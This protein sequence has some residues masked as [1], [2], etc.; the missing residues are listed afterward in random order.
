MVELC[1]IFNYLPSSICVIVMSWVLNCPLNCS[2]STP[3]PS[4]LLSGLSLKWKCGGCFGSFTT[5][6][7]LPNITATSIIVGRSM[8][9]SCTH[10]SATF[11]HRVMHVLSQHSPRVGSISSS[12]LPSLHSCHACKPQMRK[13][14]FETLKFSSH[15]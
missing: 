13:W 6:L 7:S 11:M 10:R 2:L 3:P 4:W 9:S 5:S 14:S 8:A 1:F 15:F 12:S